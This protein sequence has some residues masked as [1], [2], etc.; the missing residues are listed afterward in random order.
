[1]K[2]TAVYVSG[3]PDGTTVEELAEYFSKAGL[4][5]EDFDTGLPR[6][7]LYGANDALVVYLREPSVPLAI[8]LFDESVFKGAVIRV[9]PGSFAAAQDKPCADN[10]DT[11]AQH[12]KISKEEWQKRMEKLREKLAWEDEEKQKITLIEKR[13]KAE[14]TC[15]LYN[16]FTCDDFERDPGFALDLLEDVREEAQKIGKLHH[17]NPVKILEQEECVAV[18]FL[19]RQHAVDCVRVMDNRW[20]GGRR[21]RACLYDGTFKL[22]TSNLKPS[23]HDDYAEEERLERFGDWLEGN[24]SE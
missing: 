17:V 5:M 12:N 4:F 16:M 22:R 18:R 11:D 13:L 21:V 20:Y 10:S 23:I 6:I 24:E 2:Q 9:E 1:M 3:L 7:K 14:C 15:L 8:S 19:D